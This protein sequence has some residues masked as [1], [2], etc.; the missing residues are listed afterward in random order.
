M[1][2]SRPSRGRPSSLDPPPAPNEGGKAVRAVFP[3]VHVMTCSCY[4]HHPASARSVR[5]KERKKRRPLVLACACTNTVCNLVRPSITCHE[6]DGRGVPLLPKKWKKGRR[7]RSL[8]GIERER[9][10]GGHDARAKGRHY[11][12]TMRQSRTYIQTPRLVLPVPS[13]A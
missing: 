9:E 10:R 8:I 12:P 2:L 7:K 1:S 6:W 11:P 13:L 4:M 3:S 5:E